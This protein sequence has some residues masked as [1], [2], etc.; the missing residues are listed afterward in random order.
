M[1]TV[2]FGPVKQETALVKTTGSAGIGRLDSAAWS[3]KFRPM[4]MNLRT[5]WT[6]TP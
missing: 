3:A 4:A 1:T 2:S 6:G 5:P